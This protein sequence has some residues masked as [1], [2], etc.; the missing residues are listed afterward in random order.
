MIQLIPERSLWDLS[1]KECT[2]KP[3]IDWRIIS[4]RAGK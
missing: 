2:L 4:V 3:L 1:M